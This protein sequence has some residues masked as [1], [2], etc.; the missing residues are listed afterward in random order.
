MVIYG[1]ALLAACLLVGMLTG[2]WLGTLAGVNRDLGGIGLSMLLLIGSTELL[3]RLGLLSE[4]VRAGISWWSGMYI[5]IVAAM[6][7]IQDV[8][9]ALGGGAAALLAGAT[10]VLAGFGMT[11]V[12]CRSSHTEVQE[13]DLP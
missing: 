2:S 3:R 8:K 1:T 13:A 10:A 12:L 5:P 7:C 11:A 9:G 6:A 4:G